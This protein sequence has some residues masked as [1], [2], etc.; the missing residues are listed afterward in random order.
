MPMCGWVYNQLHNHRVFTHTV[1]QPWIKKKLITRIIIAIYNPN[2][3]E[4]EAGEY[5][6]SLPGFHSEFKASMLYLE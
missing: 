3:H 6:Q 1:N 5:R 2:I 4:A